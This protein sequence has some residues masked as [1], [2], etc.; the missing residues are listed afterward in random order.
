VKKTEYRAMKVDYFYT[1]CS[2]LLAKG[3]QELGHTKNNFV[4]I[5][6]GWMCKVHWHKYTVKFA[7]L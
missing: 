7:R 1:F 5:K 3:W 2:K 4:F 6:K